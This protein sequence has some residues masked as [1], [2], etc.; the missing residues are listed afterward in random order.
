MWG[1]WGCRCGRGFICLWGGYL[2]KSG[3][4]WRGGGSLWAGAAW[5]CVGICILMG[6]EYLGSCELWWDTGTYKRFLVAK[7]F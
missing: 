7:T 6:E 4:G 3:W 5:W 1:W 2:C